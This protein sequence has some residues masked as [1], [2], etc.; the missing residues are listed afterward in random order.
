MTHVHAGGSAL[1]I[2]S[3][4]GNKIGGETGLQ[5]AG[6]ALAAGTSKGSFTS[7]SGLN[8]VGTVNFCSIVLI[9]SGKRMLV[10]CGSMKA[11]VAI[12]LFH[13]STGTPAAHPLPPS[14]M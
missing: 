13:S 6:S 4:E 2:K 5:C 12:P 14:D 7:S 1:E 11:V 3:T 8:F 10:R 9:I